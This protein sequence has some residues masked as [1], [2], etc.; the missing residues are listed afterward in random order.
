MSTLGRPLGTDGNITQDLGQSIG[1]VPDRM[2]VREVHSVKAEIPRS[3]MFEYYVREWIMKKFRLYHSD[4]ISIAYI[5][6][7]DHL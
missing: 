3:Y 7:R 6:S 2:G 5:R 1:D 4:N